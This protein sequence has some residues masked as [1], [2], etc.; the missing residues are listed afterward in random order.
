MSK[1]NADMAK[2]EGPDRTAV[3]S[4]KRKIE[5]ARTEKARYQGDEGQ[6]FKDF[7]SQGGNRWALKQALRLNK[8]DLPIAQADL[9]ALLSYC[10]AMDIT[11]Q[12]DLFEAPITDGPSGDG[13]HAAGYDA[14]R[15]GHGIDMCPHAPETRERELWLAGWR[16][17]QAANVPSGPAADEDI[18]APIPQ[19]EEAR[20][21]RQAKAAR[22]ERVGG[23]L[24]DVDDFGAG[25]QPDAAE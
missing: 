21:K 15:G 19:L 3:L 12:R 1:Q 11:T 18:D 6:C 23:G 22:G 2:V 9:R 25:E 8:L 17:G 24:S 5:A 10:E 14:G 13:I 16:E 20:K 7:E 4:Y